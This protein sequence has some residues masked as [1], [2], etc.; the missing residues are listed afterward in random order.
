[1]TRYVLS[2]LIQS[3]VLLL[4]VTVI[5]FGLIHAAPGGPSAVMADQSCP[6]LSSRACVPISGSISQFPFST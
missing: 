2:R 4:I 3:I 6:R 5:V 1:M